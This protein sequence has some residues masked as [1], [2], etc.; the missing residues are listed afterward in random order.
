[1]GS[2]IEYVTI[3]IGAN[4][5]CTSSESTMTSVAEFRSQFT[6][7]MNNLKSRAPNARVYVVSI[8]DIYNLW[9]VLKNN[10]NARSRWSLYNICQSM[11]ANPTS[12]STTDAERRARVKQRNIDF[13]TVLGEVCAAYG[14]NCHYDGNAIFN[15]RFEARDVST[16]DYFHPSVAGEAKLAN[17]AWLASGFAK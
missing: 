2:T 3:L 7:A 12:T 15:T 6:N 16:L 1:V 10:S 8:P 14:S 13:N 4:D 9:D 11:L 5:V 17:A